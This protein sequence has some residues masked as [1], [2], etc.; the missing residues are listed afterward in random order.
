MG[1]REFATYVLF[2]VSMYDVDLSRLFDIRQTNN[3][4]FIIPGQHIYIYIYTTFCTDE[5]NHGE[6][7]ASAD[8]YVYMLLNF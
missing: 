7:L 6:T 3:M 4:C 8:K 2:I 5:P 1:S